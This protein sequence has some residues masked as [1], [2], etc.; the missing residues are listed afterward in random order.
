MQL[1]ALH[2]QNRASAVQC[3][4]LPA[5]H[6]VTTTSDGASDNAYTVD[7]NGSMVN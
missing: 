4:M 3:I 6:P 5:S 7:V 2:G 1:S